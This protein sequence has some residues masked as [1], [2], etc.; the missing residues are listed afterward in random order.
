VLETRENIWNFA[1]WRVIPT[2]LGWRKNGSN[3]MGRGLAAQAAARYPSLSQQ[4]GEECRRLASQNE[5]GLS[6]YHEYQLIMFP[7]KPLVS[8]QPHMSWNQ[9]ASYGLIEANLQRL[10]EML[11]LKDH[12]RIA[13]PLVGCGNGNLEPKRVKPLMYEALDDRFMLY[14]P[15]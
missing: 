15:A 10:Q 7:V 12:S 5:D 14:I 8:A 9:S 1:G 11:M 6:P 3:V 4:Y 2:N 13:V